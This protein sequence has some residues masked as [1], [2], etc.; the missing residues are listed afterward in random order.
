MARKL[1][2]EGWRIIGDDDKDNPYL[3]T[4]HVIDIGY[5]MTNTRGPKTLFLTQ[6]GPHDGESS[7]FWWLWPIHNVEN[8]YDE[9][10]KGKIIQQLKAKTLEGAKRQALRAAKKFMLRISKRMV[11]VDIPHIDQL[12]KKD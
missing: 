6:H 4:D 10:E 7:F 11:E 3:I 9:D 5:E 8:A 12:L 2:N 1:S